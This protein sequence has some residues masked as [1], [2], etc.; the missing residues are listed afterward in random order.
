MKE[1]IKYGILGALS[2]LTDD[3]EI[4]ETEILVTA[5]KEGA[6]N[7]LSILR[8]IV[9]LPSSCPYRLCDI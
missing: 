1:L 5:L 2:F 7:N 8:N 9:L 4:E 6:F 3:T